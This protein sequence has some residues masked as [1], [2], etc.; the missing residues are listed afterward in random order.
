MCA[1]KNARVAGMY[2]LFMLGLC[3]YVLAALAASTFC[4][5]EPTTVEILD[6]VDTAIC[7]VFLTDFCGKLVTA[8]S[9]WGYLKWGWID[10]VSSIPTI[11]LLRWGRLSRVVRILRLL[12]GV[13]SSKSIAEFLLKRRAQSAFAAAALTALL[14]VVYSSIVMLHFEQGNPQANIRTAA[15]S[16]WWAIVTV[17]TVGYGDRYPVTESGR[18]VAVVTMT[19]GVALFGTFTA[20]VASWFLAPTELEQEDEL[21]HIRRRLTAIEEQLRLLVRRRDSHL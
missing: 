3:V 2:E 11:G 9:K 21:V 1:A 6:Y 20:F 15:D 14:T 19:A 16:L 5:L 17:T 13:R 12:R 8:K 10:L 7:F 4:R 18:V